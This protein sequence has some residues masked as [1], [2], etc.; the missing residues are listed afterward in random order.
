MMLGPPDPDTEARW[1]LLT[2]QYFICLVLHQMSGPPNSDTEA[3]CYLPTAHLRVVVLRQNSRSP[4]T[5]APSRVC[6]T[7]C[8]SALVNMPA[9]TVSQTSAPMRGP[10]GMRSTSPLFKA[11]LRRESSRLARGLLVGVRALC[12]LRCATREQ[13]AELGVG[14]ACAPVVASGEW[15]VV[16]GLRSRRAVRACDAAQR[17]ARAPPAVTSRRRPY[18]GRSLTSRSLTGHVLASWW[19]ARQGS[20]ARCHSAVASRAS[21]ADLVGVG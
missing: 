5:R 11:R 15:R 1:T 13:Q 20:S 10:G 17:P 2:Y 4:R 6:V 3:R 7:L 12:G 21:A 9:P 18:C 8:S 19:A 14:A 16:S